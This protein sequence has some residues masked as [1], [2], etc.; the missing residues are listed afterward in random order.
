VT[1]VDE[2]LFSNGAPGPVAKRLRGLYYEW[3]MRP[4]MRQEVAYA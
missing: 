2:R 3:M 1:K 4:A